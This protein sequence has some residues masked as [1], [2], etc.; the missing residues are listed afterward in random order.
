MV[1][2]GEGEDARRSRQIRVLVVDDEPEIHRV[3][4]PALKACGYEPLKAMTGGEALKMIA[5]S[6]P[7][8]TVLDLGL[9]DMDGK[10]VLREARIFSDAPII[11]LSARDDEAEKIAALDAGANDYVEKPFAIGELMARVRAALRHT[12]CKEPPPS[13]IEALGLIVD[14]VKHQ[15][16]KHGIKINL[17]PKEYDLLLVLARRPGRL[18]T[19]N[20]ILRSVWGPAHQNDLQYLRVFIGKLRAK[21]EDDPAVP[22]IIETELG[23]GY[24]FL[25]SEKP[26]SREE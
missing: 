23:V 24:R 10:E 12:P 14:T 8:V 3:L 21:I 16:T 5:A 22:R 26:L 19:H 11:I 1:G 7:D 2:D 18:V 20:E 13:R 4:R 6:A 17:T 15:V 25:E 9:T